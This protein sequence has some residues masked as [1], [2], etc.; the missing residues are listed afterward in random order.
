MFMKM[1]EWYRSSD[2]KNHSDFSV[3]LK[4]NWKNIRHCHGVSVNA[5]YRHSLR[6]A[7]VFAETGKEPNSVKAAQWVYAVI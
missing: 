3:I 7:T 5:L 2:E 4:Y 6:G 1:W